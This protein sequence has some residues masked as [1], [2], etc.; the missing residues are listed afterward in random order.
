MT[1]ENERT[2][3][4]L[5]VDLK[6]RGQVQAQKEHRSFSSL[7]VVALEDYLNRKD[8]EDAKIQAANN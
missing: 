3:L 8:A 7:V 5:P 1:R 6:A 4:N 2:G